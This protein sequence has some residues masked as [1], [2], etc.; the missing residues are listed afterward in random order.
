MVTISGGG[1]GW[2]EDDKATGQAGGEGRVGT[3]SV[4][5]WWVGGYNP[6]FYYTT[7]SYNNNMSVYV[8][9]H[10]FGF[11]IALNSRLYFN[12]HFRLINTERVF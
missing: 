8:L 9:S 10:M 3:R 6:F 5:W 1:G 7:L 11:F 12:N 2:L 4:L